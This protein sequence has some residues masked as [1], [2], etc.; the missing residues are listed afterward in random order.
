MS[1]NGKMREGIAGLLVSCDDERNDKDLSAF[2]IGRDK[3]ILS[4]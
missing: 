4:S 3:V 1:F 2:L